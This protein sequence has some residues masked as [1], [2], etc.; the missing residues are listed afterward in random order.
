MNK[1]DAIGYKEEEYKKVKDDVLKLLQGI[2]YKT[3]DVNFIPCS[4]Y[5]GDNITKK[6]AN[7]PYYNGPTLIE[8]LT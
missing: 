6:S 3:D 7:T 8:A 2:G 1:M 5:A 4:G